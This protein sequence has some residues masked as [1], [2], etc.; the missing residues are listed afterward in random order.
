ML[1]RPA[2]E[3]NEPELARI[4]LATWTMATS[5]APRP[6]QDREYRFFGKHTELRDVLV[7]EVDGHPVGY[8]KLRRPTL[9]PSNGH[10]L[11][12][13]GLAVDPHRQRQGAGRNLVEAAVQEASQQGGRKL[14]LRVLGTNVAV[15]GLYAMCGFV[16]E[17]VLRQEFYLDGSYV[18]DLLMARY[19]V[20]A[21][22]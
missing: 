20:A 4:D 13:G 1:V 8:V 11:Q 18:D 3:G 6:V 10:V 7:A 16:V 15:Q 2:V 14:T 21:V 9:L 22:P 19:L 12:I 5:P 17:G